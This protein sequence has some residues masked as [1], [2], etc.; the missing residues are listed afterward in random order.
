MVPAMEAKLERFDD[1]HLTTAFEALN[2]GRWSEARDAFT[3]VSDAG[4]LPEANY[5]LALSLWWLGDMAGTID[6]F[7]CAYAGFRHRRDHGHAAG[8]ALRLC[9]HQRAHLANDSAAHGW[10]ARARRIIEEN[11]IEDLR[12]E[13]YLMQAC[14]DEDP[15]QAEALARQALEQARQRNDVDLELRALSWLGTALVDQGM[16]DEGMTL[17]DEAVAA[18]L[19]GEPG[20]LDTVVFT[21]CN[22][23]TSCARCSAFE[24]AVKWVRAARRFAD[25]Y[26]C[27]FLFLECQTIHG[28][29]LVAT[30][31]WELAESELQKAIDNSRDSA[32]G[33]FVQSV[34]S[35]AELRL[36]QGRLDEAGILL[37]GL[38]AY[39]PALPVVA[40][41]RLLIGDAESAAMAARNRLVTIG[42]DRLESIRV[43]EILAEA[44]LA[45]GV[46]ETAQTWGP[47][48]ADMG[49]RRGCNVAIAR[50]YRLEGLG[51][52]VADPDEAIHSLESAAAAFES[53]E[54][55]YEVARTYLEGAR[56][57]GSIRPEV[58][59]RYGRSALGAFQK[60]GAVRDADDAA[61]LLRS[62][63]VSTARP[64]PRDQQ[65]L[66]RREN[67]VLAL[68]GSGLS[69]PE[70]AERLFISRKTVEHHVANVLS[71]MALKNRTE[72]AAEAVRRGIPIQVPIQVPNR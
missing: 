69:N 20:D 46:S 37:A 2:E 59:R 13:L 65:D 44:D 33:Y 32:P 72:A 3:A 55:P 34:A 28:A 56:V 71:K 41:H 15:R 50:G 10:L 14:A 58:S 22:M 68:L 39:P 23:M 7:E 26:G 21:C 60:L 1:S 53:L 66:T 48:L 57:L 24:R 47:R 67:E 38:E 4:D 35:L 30:G 18:S 5:G 52:T 64:A 27:P 17:L 31:D 36:C 43:I 25:R 61:A 6:H 9:L 11:D 29:V 49:R 45:R 63:G 40:R 42:T 70:I 62:L 54:M 51:I 16:T 8:V 12:G 19:A